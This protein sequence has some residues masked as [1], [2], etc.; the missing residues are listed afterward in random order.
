M[1]SSDQTLAYVSA[2]ADMRFLM[3]PHMCL[4]VRRNNPWRRLCAH[5]TQYPIAYYQ[6]LQLFVIFEGCDTLKFDI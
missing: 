6:L 2:T 3:R 5:I 1:R 4:T